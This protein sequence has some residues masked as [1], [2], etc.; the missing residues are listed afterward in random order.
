[1]VLIATDAEGHRCLEALHIGA[2]LIRL[3]SVDR[4]EASS[5]THVLATHRNSYADQWAAVHN[6]P[7]VSHLWLYDCLKAGALLSPVEQVDDSYNLYWPFAA[8]AIP[9]AQGIQATLSGITGPLR[10]LVLQL[11]ASMGLQVE[12][13]M[14]VGTITYIVV[15]DV[16]EQ[17]HKLNAIRNLPR[18]R[19]RARIKVVNL[20]WVYDCLRQ[21]TLLPADA[22]QQNLPPEAFSQH[23]A[24]HPL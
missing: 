22:Y 7:A 13:N 2:P 4:P 11:L 12:K 17:S 10:G 1:M 14:C 20:M 18:G 16:H 9:Q 3:V 21:W 6:K 24:E 15:R 23:T 5:S 19:D 8:Q